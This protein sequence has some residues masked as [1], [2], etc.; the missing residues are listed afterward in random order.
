MKKGRFMEQ[1]RTQYR[2]KEGTHCS[3][4]DL[5]HDVQPSGRGCQQCL[6]LGDTWVHLRLCRTCGQVG[7]CDDSKN[8]HAR[9]HYHAAAHP[10]I[11]SFE[12]G[13]NWLW[14]YADEAY[15]VPVKE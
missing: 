6:E 7:C 3:H 4:L 9:A 12:P 15:L 2:M 11:Q 1:K 13:E 10:V 5:I 8:K 14:C